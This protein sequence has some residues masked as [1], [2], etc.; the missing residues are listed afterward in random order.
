MPSPDTP[1]QPVRRC[2][3][4]VSRRERWGLTLKGWFVM[5]LMLASAGLAGLRAIHPFLAVTAPVETRVVAVEAWV[6]PVIL[7]GV[8]THFEDD[9]G[10]VFYCTG[11]PSDEHFDSTRLEDTSAAEAV[12]LLHRHGI[13]QDRLRAVP[14]WVPR[15]DRTYANAVALRAWFKENKV[16]VTALNVVTEG[17]HARRSRLLF[18]KAFGETVTIGVIAV[19]DP[20]YDAEHWWRYS[21][22]IKAVISES[23]GYL[24]ARLLFQPAES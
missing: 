13:P 5:G 14:A 16:P 15:R 10:V 6:P 17:L 1:S 24:Y 8:A 19:P 9:P 4:L 22:G 3:G 23:A 7:K 21:E 18:Q 2:L 20:T 11:G 12:R